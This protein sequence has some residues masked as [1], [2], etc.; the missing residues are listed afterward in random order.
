MSRLAGDLSKFEARWNFGIQVSLEEQSP[1]QQVLNDYVSNFLKLLDEVQPEIAR[2]EHFYEKTKAE[3]NLQELDKASDDLLLDRL[4]QFGLIAETL[5]D[6]I[7]IFDRRIPELEGWHNRGMAW[8]KEAEELLMAFRRLHTIYKWNETTLRR[9]ADQRCDE[10][11][12]RHP[13]RERLPFEPLDLDATN[14]ARLPPV[15]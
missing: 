8:S 11:E 15:L 1:G 6:R 7:E 13:D 14:C 12:R 5:L 10:Y 3:P 4:Y 2:F 9:W